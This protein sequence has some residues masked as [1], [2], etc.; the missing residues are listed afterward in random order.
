MSEEK[1]VATPLPIP[2]IETQDFWQAAKEG[3]LGI[4][5]NPQ[6]GKTF[7]YPRMYCPDDWGQKAEIRRGSGRGTIYSYIVVHRHA[8]PGFNA[9]VPYVVALIDL[10]EGPR[11]MSR[12]DG[13]PK[14]VKVGAKVEVYFEEM[15]DEINL[16]RFK[17]AE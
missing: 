3:Y 17:L 11:M 15:N 6:T 10:E 1:K 12:V 5:T 7:W 13:N 14:E 9:Q 4:P 16:P 8:H 2:D